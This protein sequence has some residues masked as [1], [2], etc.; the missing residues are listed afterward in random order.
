MKL[1]S[2]GSFLGRFPQF[3]PDDHTRDPEEWAE[4]IPRW[5][6]ASGRPRL[7]PGDPAHATAPRMPGPA[8]GHKPPR[9]HHS[10]DEAVTPRPPAPSSAPG[11]R[12][13]RR[14]ETD[15]PY[16]GVNATGK[17][18]QIQPLK[19]PPASPQGAAAITGSN[20]KE[21]T[22]TGSTSSKSSS[23]PSPPIRDMSALNRSVT[24]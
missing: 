10:Q 14:G 6:P 16:R 8:T 2:P 15:L 3:T 11:S 22:V 19:I 23:L 24:T 21:M 9:S 18:P 7:N 1:L 20:S 13:P 4:G 5:P 12:F 17:S